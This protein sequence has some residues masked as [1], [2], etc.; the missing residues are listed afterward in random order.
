MRG[1]MDGDSLDRWI[2]GNYGADQFANVYYTDDELAAM[3]MDELRECEDDGIDT[4]G[5]LHRRH[6]EARQLPDSDE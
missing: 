2:T 5:W 1:G 6:R 3:T 4:R